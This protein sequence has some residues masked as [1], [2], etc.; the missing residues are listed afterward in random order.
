MAFNAG[1]AHCLKYGMTSNHVLVQEL[2]WGMGKLSSS[3]SDRSSI[4]VPMR[5][6]Y[7]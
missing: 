7:S 3:V 6:A 4:A 5:S 1:G 2:S